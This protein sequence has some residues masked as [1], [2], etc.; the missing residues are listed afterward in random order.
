MPLKHYG[1]RVFLAQ[2]LFAL[3]LCPMMIGQQKLKMPLPG[4]L[5]PQ[6]SMSSSRRGQG[7]LTDKQMERRMLK[8]LQQKHS[9]QFFAACVFTAYNKICLLLLINLCNCIH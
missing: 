9:P 5:I 4:G 1:Q 2:K 6:N 8:I 7:C 3:S